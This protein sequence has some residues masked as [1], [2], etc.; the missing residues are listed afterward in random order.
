MDKERKH[1][2]DR[3]RWPITTRMSI[4]QRVNWLMWIIGDMPCQDIVFFGSIDDDYLL[5]FC[6]AIRDTDV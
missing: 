3:M 6:S 1:F 5:I 2:F 4:D